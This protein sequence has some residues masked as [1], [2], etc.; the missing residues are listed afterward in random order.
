[1]RAWKESAS[2]VEGCGQVVTMAVAAELKV[3]ALLCFRS[4][5]CFVDLYDLRDD[6]LLVCRASVNLGHRAP[7]TLVAHGMAFSGLA[8]SSTLFVPDVAHG[9]VCVLPDVLGTYDVVKHPCGDR[10]PIDVA[11]VQDMVAVSFRTH[12]LGIVEIWRYP[13]NGTYQVLKTLTTGLTQIG[14]SFSVD[15]AVLALAPASTFFAHTT[16]FMTQ[17]QDEERGVQ[18]MSTEDWREESVWRHKDY[19]TGSVV[20]HEQEGWLAATSTGIRR[21]VDGTVLVPGFA[22]DFALIPKVGLVKAVFGN[23]DDAVFLVTCPDVVAMRAMS[24]ERVQWMAV[25]ARGIALG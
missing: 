5:C 20:H 8:G 13:G 4:G 7:G 21:M 10:G 14:V 24:A 25:V 3:L 16:A 17:D 19:S 9:E 22:H 11:C 15:G 12:S 2:G 18:L 6:Q 23:P 1:M